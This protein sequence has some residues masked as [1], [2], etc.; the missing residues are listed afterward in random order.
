MEPAVTPI[1]GFAHLLAQS[2]AVGKTLLAVL[3][4][5]SIASWALIAIK[6][7]AQRRRQRRSAAFLDMFWNA[8]TLDAVHYEI[9]THGAHDPFLHLS[10]HALH[11]QAHEM[12]RVSPRLHGA[13]NASDF[14][15]RTIKSV[16]PRPEIHLRADQSLAYRAVA[17]ALGDATRA[18]LTRVGFASQPE[19]R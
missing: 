13:G 8:P 3:V 17:Q 6:G 16:L 7:F 19:S 10:A 18:G 12:R 2:D 14:I 9:S 4:L 11:A 15:T 1:F 5:M